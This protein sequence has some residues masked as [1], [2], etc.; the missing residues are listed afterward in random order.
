MQFPILRPKRS[1]RC[2]GPA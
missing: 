1:T 2:G